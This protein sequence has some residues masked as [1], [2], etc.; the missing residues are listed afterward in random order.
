MRRRR[1]V[2]HRLV[3]SANRLLRQP[4]GRHVLRRCQRGDVRPLRS[5]VQI[6]AGVLRPDDRL[7]QRPQRRVRLFLVQSL[8]RSGT[9]TL[10]QVIRHAERVGHD[11]QRRRNTAGRRHEAAVDHVE[12]RHLVAPTEAVEHGRRGIG[13]EAAG[14][15]LE[16]E[17]RRPGAL[18]R[19]SRWRRP[20]GAPP[21]PCRVATG[22]SARRP[23]DCGRE[24]S[25][26]GSA[27]GPSPRRRRSRRCRVRQKLPEDLE[28]DLACVVV[29][30]AERAIECLAPERRT[31]PP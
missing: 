8:P 23:D 24:S 29:V 14:T 27:S 3:Q 26:T 31:P 16:H 21:G 25:R 4:T 11:R 13:T 15:V 22:C 28:L 2:H 18:R 6:V 1:V 20:P 7:C 30:A 12:I 10:H 17:G 19:W 9:E 5:R